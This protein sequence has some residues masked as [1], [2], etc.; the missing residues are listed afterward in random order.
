MANP[1]SDAQGLQN[2]LQSIAPD[3]V[4][5]VTPEA[6]QRLTE[7][8]SELMGEDVVRTAFSGADQGLPLVDITDGGLPKASHDPR[9]LVE[10]PPLVPLSSLSASERA[11]N[12]QERDHILDLLEQ[13]E[14]EEQRKTDERERL[15][16]QAALEKRKEASRGELDKLKMVKET[17][18]K[19]GKALMRSMAEARETQEVKAKE[20]IASDEAVQKAVTS[21]GSKKKTVTFADAESPSTS[22]NGLPMDWGDVAKG[23]LRSDTKPDLPGTGSER[24]MK[25][26]VVERFPGSKPSAQSAPQ[27]R[28]VDSDDESEPDIEDDDSDADQDLEEDEFDLDYALHQREIALAYQ[29]KREKIGEEAALALTSHTHDPDEDPTQKSKSKTPVSKFRANRLASAYAAS[30][31]SQSIGASVVPVAGADTLQRA[32]RMGNIDQDGRLVGGEHESEEE[33]NAVLNEQENEAVQEVLDLLTK[34][35]VYN[36]GPEGELHTVSAERSTTAPFTM[37]TEPPPSARQ[38][39]K[40][41]SKFK[42]ARNGTTS[43]AT[44]E[45]SASGSSTP[46]SNLDRSSPK[47][48]GVSERAPPSSSPMTA[49]PVVESPSFPG[50]SAVIESPSFPSRAATRPERPP[51]VMASAVKERGIAPGGRSTDTQQPPSSDEPPKRVSRFKAERM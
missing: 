32:I 46:I 15:E 13:E 43:S 34:G 20:A 21:N 4:D 30:S 37:P 40:A 18:K 3:A 2:L 29:E 50:I 49:A 47:L 38:K 12:K 1:Q 51:A 5:N 25:K 31:P 19:M 45:T 22:S 24:L 17:H 14:E 33:D 35:Q 16:R 23:K 8:L 27:E 11:R 41:P 42:L 28:E 7:K 36:A 9:S 39:E 6:L 10:E 26:N 48:P 44:R